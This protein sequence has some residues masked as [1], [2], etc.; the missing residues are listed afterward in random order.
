VKLYTY[1]AAPNP[2]R[3][4]VFL[5]EKGLEIPCQV[6][7]IMK[8]ENR[9]PEFIEKRNVMGGLPV[10]ELDDGSHL[11][12]SVAICRYLEALHPDPPLFGRSPE[13][14]GRI[15]MWIR[16]IELNFMMQVGLVWLHGSP[17]TRAVVKQQLPEMAAQAR[18]NV[19]SYYR[20]LDRQLAQRPFIAGD[21]YGMPDILALTT[22]DF[23]DGLVELHPPPG[24]ANL[25]R[26]HREVSARPAVSQASR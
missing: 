3:V 23:A 12:E 4:H 13:E 5:A 14:Q 9:T 22:Y 11:A 16:R 25:E 1:P 24:L 15:E 18:E 2:R 19:A 6:V 20:F 8:R 17:L 26:W 7:D 10:L 21:A